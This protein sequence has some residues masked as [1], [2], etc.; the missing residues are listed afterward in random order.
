MKRIFVLLA[1]AALCVDWVRFTGK[2]KA[3]NLKTST[4]TI[5]NADGDLLTVPIDYQVK[6][7]DKGGDLR[8]LKDLQLNQKVTLTRTLSE[9]PVEE[10]EGLAPQESP[11]RGR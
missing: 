8:G 7:A 10:T 1:V 5:Q 4:L 2:V 9:A 11:H 3:I 6:I